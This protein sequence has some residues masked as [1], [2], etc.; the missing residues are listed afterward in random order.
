[1]SHPD[2]FLLDPRKF[3]SITTHL[4][5]QADLFSPSMT[6]NLYRGRKQLASYEVHEPLSPADVEYVRKDLVVA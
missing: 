5:D 3:V 1:M 2:K 6:V 4:G